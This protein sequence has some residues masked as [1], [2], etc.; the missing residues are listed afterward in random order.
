MFGPKLVTIEIE[1]AVVV[2]VADGDAGLVGGLAGAAAVHAGLRGHVGERSVLVVVVERVRGARRAVDEI[3]V[4]EAVVVVVDPG[5][6]RAERLDHVLLG[7]GPGLVDEV[8]LRF[9][10]HVHERTRVTAAPG[11][12]RLGLSDTGLTAWTESKQDAQPRQRA[13]H[14]G[15]SRAFSHFLL[16]KLVLKQLALVLRQ[17]KAEL[18]GSRRVLEGERVETLQQI[19]LRQM[20]VGRPVVRDRCSGLSGTRRPPH[21][22][23]SA[24][25]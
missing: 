25:A 23:A 4:L 20:A 11:F 7:R 3:Q 8:D 13:S 6:A 16:A 22:A 2:V 21:R 19:H 15:P 9:G 18:L 12:G 10:G 14:L 1:I 24:A 17:R 5:D